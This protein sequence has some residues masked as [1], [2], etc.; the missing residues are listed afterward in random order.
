MKTTG[1][2][3]TGT[4]IN[5]AGIQADWSDPTFVQV[6]DG[7]SATNQPSGISDTL[8][9]TN[10]G[11]SVPSNA[12]IRGYLVLLLWSKDT[13]TIVLSGIMLWD[14]AANNGDDKATNQIPRTDIPDALLLG[15]NEDDWSSD[16]TISEINNSAFGVGLAVTQSTSTPTVSILHIKL[17]IYYDQPQINRGRFLNRSSLRGRLSF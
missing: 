14:G 16:T 8:R 13:T 2:Q 10:F 3:I 9:C 4:A 5:V 17:A 1:L 6:S 7:T 15:N 12:T 11:F